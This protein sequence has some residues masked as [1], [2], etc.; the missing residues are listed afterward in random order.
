MSVPLEIHVA[1]CG[2][3]N[4][5]TGRRGLVGEYRHAAGVSYSG[6]VVLWI[7]F[8]RRICI[9]VPLSSMKYGY[10][11]D[12]HREVFVLLVVVVFQAGEDALDDTNR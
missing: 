6:D 3:R 1:L 4:A 12:H 8:R 11:S 5:E 2:R 9:G 7:G 10:L